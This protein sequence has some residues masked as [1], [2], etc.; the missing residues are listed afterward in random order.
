MEKLAIDGGSKAVP[1]A[2]TPRSWPVITEEDI[3]SVTSALRSGVIWGTE[4]P[5]VLGLQD[6]WAE[7]C[8]AKYCKGT[9]G[10]TAAIH[11]GLCG[12]GVEAGDEVIVPA[13]T[14]HSSASAIL[15]HNA[16]PVFVDIDF[17]TYTI[18]WRKVE[19]KITD[20]TRA[21]IGVDLFG[22]PAN[23][24]EINKIARKNDIK[25]VEDGCQ[26]HGAAINGKKTG[27]LTDIAAFSLNGSKNLPGAEGGLLVTNEWEFMEAAAKLEM[28][29]RIVDGKR[30]YPKYSFG[31]NY[32]MN[33]LAAALTRSQLKKLPELNDKRRGNCQ[34]LSNALKKLEGLTP[35]LE[36]EGYRHVYHMY[37]VALDDSLVEK[38]DV[39]LKELRDGIIYALMTEGVR[40]A[41]W[42]QD[43]IPSLEIYQSQVGYGSGCPWSCPH[44][45]RRTYEYKV[46][47]YP[48]TARLVEGTFNLDYFYPPNDKDYIDAII[49]AFEK[50]WAHFD[51]LF[52]D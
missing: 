26:A 34:R 49:H 41:L 24:I 44:G 20:K 31:W 19:E 13:Y 42:V 12:V 17:D 45:S 3:E 10:G 51:T 25:T 37:K 4:A 48:A 9:N 21:I 28:N 43:M 22:L 8:G 23:W 33:E 15:H 16:I 47:E 5:N 30:I 35:P 38:Y 27:N 1:D 36:P 32:R 50:V 39:P 2:L 18:D 29:V 46:E 14:F 6:E 52:E 11:M 7:F 40:T